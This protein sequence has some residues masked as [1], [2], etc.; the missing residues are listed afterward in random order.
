M[1]RLKVQQLIDAFLNTDLTPFSESLS[2]SYSTTFRYNVI[3]A[4]SPPAPAPT[5]SATTTSLEEAI[6]LEI[7]NPTT[8]L[9]QR[10]DSWRH[11][12]DL[13]HDYGE[14]HRVMYHN[15][16]RDYERI[17][18]SVQDAPRFDSV[19][20][21]PQNG[22]KPPHEGI[23]GGFFAIREKSEVLINAATE[24]EKT[25]KSTVIPHVDRL[26]H[27]VKEHLRGLKSNG[28]KGIKDVERA[29]GLT[30]KQI[31]QLGQHTSS[32]GIFSGKP[33]PLKDPYIIYRDVLCKLDSQIMKENIQ[34]DTLLTIQRDFKTFESHIVGGIHQM[35]KLMDQ[36]QNT[37]W[38]FQRECYSA[39]TTSFTGIPP[40]FEWDQFVAS[41]KLILADE[42]APKRSIDRVKFPN[43]DHE[44]TRP[45]IEG[46]IQRKST[47]AFSKTYNSAYYVVTPSKFLHQ[48]ASK[49]Y[50]Q[51]P[52]PE[53][54]I[55]LPDANI[56][57]MYPKETGKNKFKI[58][59]KDALKTI[60]TKHTFEFKTST[61]DDLV[62]WCNVIH[63]VGTSGSGTLSQKS[64]LT[65]S[66]ATAAAAAAAAGEPAQ[67]NPESTSSPV[68]PAVDIPVA[69][70]SLAPTEAAAESAPAPAKEP[71][72]SDTA[73]PSVATETETETSKVVADNL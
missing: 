38:D 3:M 67:L 25:I 63:D 29:R 50:V 55:Y 45:L 47:M 24:A 40:E 6:P 18:K 19:E 72:A 59:A 69:G 52:E 7:N 61:Y 5:T 30:Q 73:E 16:S 43:Q 13:L 8:V 44:S 42:T 2:S 60:S 9:T 68:E 12:V 41:N 54:S 26:S 65:T 20:T 39:I 62:K 10:L 31:E 36:T 49:D 17:S 32:F 71:V 34:T 35:F 51:S 23:S 56:G 22:D 57:A 46:V 33:D 64:T 11:V 1:H 21:V 48:F 14:G 66:A 53:F 4:E 15:L 37:F 70:T 27:D 28:F 58:T